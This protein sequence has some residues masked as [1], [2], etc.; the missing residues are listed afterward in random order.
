MKKLCTMTQ[1]QLLSVLPRYLRQNGY[2]PKVTKEY[3]IA[4]GTL[5]ICLVAHLDTIHELEH[6]GVA[7]TTV[8]YDAKEQLMMAVGGKCADDRAG[9]YAIIQLVS[10]GY[11]PHIIFTVGEE[12]GG[13]GASAL[14][15]RM[16]KCPF[17]KVKA[18][19]QLDRRGQK[20]CVFYQCGNTSFTE[21]MESY[22]FETARGTF[23]DIS[24]IAPAWKIAAVNLSVGYENEHSSIETL[25]VIWLAETIQ[26]VRQIFD[27]VD[28]MPFFEYIAAPFTL[29]TWGFF[30]NK[31]VCIIC[32]HP[33]NGGGV[34]RTD[35]YGTYKM[36]KNCAEDL[37]D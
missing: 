32:G 26:K 12:S 4:E 8:L 25:D 24:I 3:I 23:T 10:E 34:S 33:L 31:D 36:C 30:N 16:K 5:P 37:F 13:I 6:N 27:E 18:I 9:V 1:A 2:K 21:F 20:D 28:K 14:I 17:K 29:D 7:P 15:A 11:R 22:G 35:E 19:F